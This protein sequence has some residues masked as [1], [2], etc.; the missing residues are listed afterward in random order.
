MHHLQLAQVLAACMAA[1]RYG[2]PRLVLEAIIA[3]E[4]RFA[5]SLQGR[6]EPT[7]AEITQFPLPVWLPVNDLRAH[8]HNPAER[9][10]NLHEFGGM[11]ALDQHAL[12]N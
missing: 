9:F 3:C 8:R 7:L 5:V 4:H 1:Q 6:V 12:Q 10:I 2:R 11:P